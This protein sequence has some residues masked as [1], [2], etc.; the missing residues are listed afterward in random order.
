M[1]TIRIIV[2]GRVQGVAFRRYAEHEGQRLGLDGWVRNLPSGEVELVA[3]GDQ[4]KLDELAAWAR[5]G[6]PFAKVNG[7]VVSS[8]EEAVSRSGFGV[9]R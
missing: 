2:S 4:G 6:S 9:R 3:A 8:T 7:V 5:R 1:P